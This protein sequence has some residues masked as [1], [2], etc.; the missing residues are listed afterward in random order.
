[1]I[2]LAIEGTLLFELAEIFSPDR[3][4]QLSKNPEEIWL[5]QALAN[6]P[7]EVVQRREHLAKKQ[8]RLQ[9]ALDKF[10]ER[11]G[12]SMFNMIKMKLTSSPHQTPPSWVGV[13]RGVLP[14]A[15]LGISRRAERRPSISINRPLSA[16]SSPSSRSDLSE[17]TSLTVPSRDRSPK[18][19]SGGSSVRSSSESAPKA[20][21]STFESHTSVLRNQEF[22]RKQGQEAEVEL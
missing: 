20:Y 6:E 11:L 4:Q 22:Q 15:E 19:S 21:L 13:S 1:V 10:R 16:D 18:N 14:N 9:E 7:D 8:K 3:V 5:L 12:D 17:N 2:L